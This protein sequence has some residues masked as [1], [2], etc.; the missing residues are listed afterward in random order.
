MTTH[1]ATVNAIIES[2]LRRGFIDTDHLFDPEA[3]QTQ[4]DAVIEELAEVARYLRRHRQRGDPLDIDKLSKE[5]ADTV[6]AA[7][8]LLT[9]VAGFAAPVVV[10]MTLAADEKRGW[11]HSGKTRAEFEAVQQT[12]P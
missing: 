9:Y 8:C 12:T 10:S 2:L 5:A 4:V 3:M 11:L 6:I 1:V 7:T